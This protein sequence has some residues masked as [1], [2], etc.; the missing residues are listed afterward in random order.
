MGYIYKITNKITK[1]CYIGQ[2]IVDLD[3][4]WRQ[5]LKPNSN[6][7]YLKASIKKYG[8][9]SFEFKLICICFDN[10]LDNYE[11]FYMNKYN[12]LVPNGYNLREGG[13]SGRHHEETKR[14]ISETLKNRTDIVRGKSQLGKPHTEE[15]KNKIS[16]AL[17]G[18]KQKSE[19][20]QKRRELLIK[21]NIFKIDKETGE[22]L[23]M[24]KGYVEAALNVQTSKGAIWNVCNGKSKTAKGFIWKSELI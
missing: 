19:T 9:D 16:K 14:K 3:E 7:R 24:F 10:D 6:C 5:H 17:T 4:R 18:K 1:Q 2:T 12:T 20:I 21:H 13:N 23:E 11:C 22:I 15:I 8:V